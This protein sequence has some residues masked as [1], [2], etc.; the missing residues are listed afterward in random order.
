MSLK[1]VTYVKA[2]NLTEEQK[3]KLKLPKGLTNE[4]IAI[5]THNPTHNLNAVVIKK[6]MVNY[7]LNGA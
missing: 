3:T 2:R 6:G 5:E 4:T 7:I 1:N